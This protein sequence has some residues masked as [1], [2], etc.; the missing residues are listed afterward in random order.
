MIWANTWYDPGKEADA[1]KAHIDQGADIVVQHTDSPA[2]L[3]VAQ[4]RGLMAFGQ[5]SDM[6]ALRAG[7]PAHRPGR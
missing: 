6:R 2:P 3:Q 5:A 7:G 4:E 1:A